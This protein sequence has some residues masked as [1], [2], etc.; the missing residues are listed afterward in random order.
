MTEQYWTVT[1]VVEYFEVD[2]GFLSQLEEEE[3]LCPT[4]SEEPPNKLFS[5]TDL[6]RLRLAKTLVED[7]GVNLAGVEV[8]LR[9][10]E[11]M[12]DMRRQFDAILKDLADYLKERL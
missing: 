4:C 2:E 11:S 3:I 1:E 8:V 5:S 12:F 9:M 7:M 6:E 10:R